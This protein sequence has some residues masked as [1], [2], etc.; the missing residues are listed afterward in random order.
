MREHSTAVSVAFVSSAAN[1]T[2]FIVLPTWF[3]FYNLWVQC[4]EFPQTPFMKG[5]RYAATLRHQLEWKSTNLHCFCFQRFSALQI[6]Q[7]VKE[8][9]VQIEAELK[10]YLS[11]MLT[12]MDHSQP[13]TNSFIWQLGSPLFADDMISAQRFMQNLGYAVNNHHYSLPPH[14]CNNHVSKF[15]YTKPLIIWGSLSILWEYW[16]FYPWVT[17]CFT[18][19]CSIIILQSDDAILLIIVFFS[20]SKPTYLLQYEPHHISH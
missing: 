6:S 4:S 19:C 17:W 8:F 12:D 1:S 3:A 20:H 18:I 14:S 10:V 15:V 7:P 9:K 5:R 2:I 16:L 13:L 11:D